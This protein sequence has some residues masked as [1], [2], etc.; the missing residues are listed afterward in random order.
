MS[1]KQI[2]SDIQEAIKAAEDAIAK[3]FDIIQS[4]PD[5]E[6]IQRLNKS[7]FVVMKSNL[8]NNWTPEHH[9]FKFQYNA[10][11]L[12]VKRVDISKAYNKLKEIV[13]TGK[14]VV[15]SEGY[16]EN[17]FS[18]KVEKGGGKF[19]LNLHKEVVENLKTVLY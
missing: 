6:K 12:A 18:L 10:V 16:A 8:G 7:C 19:V 5:N 15:T 4:L 11:C 17:P 1:I 14:V 2:N 13:E 9:D 3:V